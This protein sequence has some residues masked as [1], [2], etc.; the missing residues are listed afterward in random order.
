M[1]LRRA[2]LSV[3]LAAVAVVAIPS[4]ASA[5]GVQNRDE[6]GGFGDG[7]SW[8]YV[9][10][11]ARVQV[12]QGKGRLSAAIF[13]GWIPKQDEGNGWYT[14]TCPANWRIE[15]Q[16]SNWK[17]PWGEN[18]GTNQVM[19]GGSWWVSVPQGS[20]ITWFWPKV[21]FHDPGNGWFDNI[22]VQLVN[23]WSPGGEMRFEFRCMPNDDSL[24]PN[25]RAV[26]RGFD[27]DGYDEIDD[28]GG[29][30]EGSGGGAPPA[31]LLD[32]GSDGA[33]R[34]KGDD[35][36]DYDL[37]GDGDDYQDGAGGDD[38]LFGGEGDDVEYGGEG[39]DWLR[40]DA[41]DDETY[42]GAGDDMMLGGEGDDSFDG[43]A[44]DDKA[45]GGPDAD[46][47]DGGTGAD[48]LVGDAG[49]DDVTGGS[50]NDE[51]IGY[52]GNDELSGGKGD[53]GI[54]DGTGR[55]TLVGGPGNDRI[56]SRDTNR[57]KVS[58]GTGRD[59]V[60]ADRYDMVARDCEWVYLS[61]KGMPKNP[62]DPKRDRPPVR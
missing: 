36:T 19:H 59:I 49:D 17:Y 42:G 33:D 43:G 60:I 11:N 3:A 30:D 29:D 13:P 56:S 37:A 41:G 10:R 55:D 25:R 62:P 5:I 22:A 44:E 38:Y 2:L 20:W 18:S 57:D 46:E 61:K 21:D 4:S 40:G 39:D 54:F 34:Q 23:W 48:L 50:G 12:C 53:D 14:P 15:G 32:D 58:C 24:I 8:R 52:T 47:L 51:L 35:G 16:S 1:S 6:C 31:G 28:R 26:A 27:D 45:N 9:D 7:P